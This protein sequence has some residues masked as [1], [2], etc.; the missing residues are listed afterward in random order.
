MERYF[1]KVPPVPTNIYLNQSEALKVEHRVKLAKIC[2]FPSIINTLHR[3]ENAQVCKAIEKNDFWIL[4]GKIQDVLG[5]DKKERKQFARSE[6]NKILIVL[7]MFEDDIDILSEALMNPS[8]SIKM[9]TIYIKL[10]TK[11]GKGKK[12][13]QILAEAKK[14]LK[15]KK[16]RIIK[17]A[18]I[19]KAFKDLQI[20][21][22]V[23]LLIHYL[24]NEDKIFILRQ[25]VNFLL[26]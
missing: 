2:H 8:I 5:F 6:F 16:S 9:I 7:L 12:D 11:R 21:Q 15:E 17:A 18:E 4:V 20:K 22:N 26:H 23:D 24:S 3:D 1:R 10:L 13:E 14:I 19:N 25:E